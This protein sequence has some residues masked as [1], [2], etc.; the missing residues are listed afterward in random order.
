LLGVH[1]EP[2]QSTRVV[3]ECERCVDERVHRSPPPEPV[4]RADEILDR[5]PALVAGH[6]LKQRR[7]P[8]H[9]LTVDAMGTAHTVGQ[10][11]VIPSQA[12]HDARNLELV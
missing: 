6:E 11:D 12:L 7:R 9:E 4:I 3:L 10:R 8:F 2:A 5:R 1:T